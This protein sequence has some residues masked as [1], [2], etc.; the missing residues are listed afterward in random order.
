[1]NP[2]DSANKH[3]SPELNTHGDFVKDVAFSVKDVRGLYKKAIERGAVSVKE[4]TE[5]K[6]DKGTVIIAT[7]R[8]YGDTNHTFVQRDGWTGAFLPGFRATDDTDPLTFIT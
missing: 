2:D 5:L 7:I 8:T 1:L 6:D 3:I 4:P